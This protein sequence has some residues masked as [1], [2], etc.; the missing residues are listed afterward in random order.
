MN[1]NQDDELIINIDAEIDDLDD[2]PTKTLVF[3]STFDPNSRVEVIPTTNQT[4]RQAAEVSG[5]TAYFQDLVRP[6][7]AILSLHGLP[8]SVRF[9]WSANEVNK[10]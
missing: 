3:V 1:M 10:R 2:T 7:S 5:L 4:V 6:A 8:E 9:S